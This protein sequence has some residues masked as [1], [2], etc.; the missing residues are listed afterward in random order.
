MIGYE[1]INE[2][3]GANFY[4]SP[5]DTLWPGVSNNKYLLPAYDKI[6]KAIRKVDSSN[7]VFFEPSV[8]DALGGGFYES[9]GD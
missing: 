1:I 6:Y 4:K 2:P 3:I 9:L 5:A 8:I 7:L